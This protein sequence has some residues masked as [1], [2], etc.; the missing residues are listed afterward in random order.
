MRQF[1]INATVT[2]EDLTGQAE[3][4]QVCDLSLVVP[5]DSLREGINALATTLDRVATTHPVTGREE[6]PF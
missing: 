1:R 4:E 5:P 3:A 2:I 6:V